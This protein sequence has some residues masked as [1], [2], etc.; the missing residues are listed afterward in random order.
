MSK[1]TRMVDGKSRQGDNEQVK[2]PEKILAQNFIFFGKLI[3][4]PVPDRQRSSKKL[5]GNFARK[6]PRKVLSYPT[7][8]G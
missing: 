1:Y 2:R 8:I 4:Q 7:M 3:Q 6:V 5:A